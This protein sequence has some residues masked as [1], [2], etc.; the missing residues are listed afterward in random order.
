[1][2]PVFPQRARRDADG[3][4]DARDTT[5]TLANKD[6]EAPI[7]A[8]PQLDRATDCEEK[9]VGCTEQSNTTIRAGVADRCLFAN[10]SARDT[11]CPIGLS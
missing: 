9:S 8:Q 7:A 4:A 2:P 5:C 11:A 10:V 3:V 6:S 1:M